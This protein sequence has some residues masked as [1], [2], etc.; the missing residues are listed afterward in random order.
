M[1]EMK[2]VKFDPHKHFSVE[3][4]QFESMITLWFRWGEYRIHVDVRNGRVISVMKESTTS[5]TNKQNIS[6][7]AVPPPPPDNGQYLCSMERQ[8]MFKPID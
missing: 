8:W 4:W 5:P 7:P 2:I 6:Q 3:E 1:K